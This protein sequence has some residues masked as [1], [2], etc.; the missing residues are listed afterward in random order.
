[1]KVGR[2][3]KQQINESRLLL[4]RVTFLIKFIQI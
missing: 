3:K 4:L 2:C 1:M